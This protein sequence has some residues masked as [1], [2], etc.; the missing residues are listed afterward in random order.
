ML[1]S[2]LAVV[3]E[4]S[5]PSAAHGIGVVCDDGVLSLSLL[6]DFWEGLVRLLPLV[7]V[8]RRVQPLTPSSLYSIGAIVSGALPLHLHV[9]IY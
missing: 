3:A 1:F 5:N 7:L 4:R 9:L 2:G 6:V 8:R